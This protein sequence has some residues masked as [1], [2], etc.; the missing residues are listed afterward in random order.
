MKEAGPSLV[1][2][3]DPRSLSESRV[4]GR[5][6]I[7]IFITLCKTTE[8]KLLTGQSLVVILTRLMNTYASLRVGVVGATGY[9][10]VELVRRLAHHPS[11]TLVAAMG[12]RAAGPRRVPALKHVWDQ[13]VVPESGPATGG[14]VRPPVQAS[15]GASVAVTVTSSGGRTSPR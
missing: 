4:P 7:Q 15:G 5:I 11:A 2:S 12:S 1:C 6:F 14:A 10:G 9:A 13:A 3:Q 8:A